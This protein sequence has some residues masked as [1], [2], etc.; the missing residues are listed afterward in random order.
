MGHLLK[1]IKNNIV[2]LFSKFSDIRYLAAVSSI[3]SIVYGMLIAFYET[4]S[5]VGFGL[6]NVALF[7]GKL[8]TDTKIGIAVLL[9]SFLFIIMFTFSDK[10]SATIL[11]PDL[12]KKGVLKK[13]NNI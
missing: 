6:E 11:T 10:S 1:I 8:S 2:K 9:L 7:M 4:L 5:G 3:L 13:D 12:P